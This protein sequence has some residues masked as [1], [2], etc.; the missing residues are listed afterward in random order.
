M[1]EKIYKILKTRKG[2]ETIVEGTLDYLKSYFGYTLE[3]GRSWD[4]KIKH[5]K[6]INT[7]KSFIT[8]LKKSFDQAEGGYDRTSIELIEG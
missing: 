3:V 2:R 5:P 6:D 4:C 8:N 1:S 7:I